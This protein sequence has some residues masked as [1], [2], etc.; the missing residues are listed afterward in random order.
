[1]DEIATITLC[2]T[3]LTKVYRSGPVA[4]HAL[5]GVDV[6]LYEGELVVPS[7]RFT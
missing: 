2:G 7:S 6:A 4:I 3:G 5:R 1:M